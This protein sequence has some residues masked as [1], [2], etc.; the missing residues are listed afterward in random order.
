MLSGV[1][2]GWEI[3]VV[4][5]GVGVVG[6]GDKV[7]LGVVAVERLEE[8]ELLGGFDAFG[9]DFHFEAVG[10]VDDG[11]D[12]FGGVFGVGGGVEELGRGDARGAGGDPRQRYGYCFGD[13]C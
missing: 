5:G 10:E 6:A 12:D 11:A 1:I 9:G 8:G 13:S 2:G 4:G 3:E 7:A